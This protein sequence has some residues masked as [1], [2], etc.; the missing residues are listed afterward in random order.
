MKKYILLSLSTLIT[1]LSFGQVNTYYLDEWP[2]SSQWNYNPALQSKEKIFVYIPA[3]SG[4]HL[5]A[6]HTGFTY[7]DAVTDNT[8]EFSNLISVL[9]D[10]NHLLGGFNSDLFAVGMKFGNVQVRAGVTANLENRFTYTK[11]LMELSWLGNGHE[12]VIGRRLSMDGVGFNTMAYMSYFLGGSVSLLDNSLNVGLNAKLYNGIGTVYTE[13]SAFGFYTN[14]DNYNLTLDGS[15]DVN[16]SGEELT[17]DDAEID[18]FNPLSGEGNSGMGLDFGVTFKPIESFTLEASAM[19]IGSIDWTE[20]PKNYQ[21]TDQEITYSGFEL[22]EFI[23]E[24]DSAYSTIEQFVDSI[25]DLFI[26]DEGTNDFNTSMN[27]EFFVRGVYEFSS[28]LKASAYYSSKKSF[29]TNFSTAGATVSKD[30]GNTVRL[31]GGVQLFRMKDVLIPLGVIINAGPV[32][33]GLHTDNLLSIIPHDTKHVS[34]MFSVGF[35]FG[36]ENDD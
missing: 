29:G 16:T 5:R 14:E 27:S 19:N 21:L 15:F 13:K 12:D 34:G 2:A 20:D 9:E 36:K 31:R 8:I 32:Q 35:R 4:F 33:L 11:D 25:S 28:R 22:D 26:P 10:E 3:L 7:N 24:P 18:S 17:V 30:L 1:V 6:G 23:N